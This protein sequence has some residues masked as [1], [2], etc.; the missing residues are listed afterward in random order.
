MTIAG[1]PATA[2]ALSLETENGIGI[3]TIDVPGESVNALSPAVVEEF[4]AVLDRIDRDAGIRAVVLMSGKPEI[5]IAGADI[6]QFT[7]IGS[8]T[9]G[10]ALSRGGQAM[11]DRLERLRA[12]VVAA[13]HG[14]CLGGGLEASLTS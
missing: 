11:M 7:T 5:F 6:E 12:P 10:E 13:I 2:H 9:E 8:A 14:A 4:A 3:I 1:A